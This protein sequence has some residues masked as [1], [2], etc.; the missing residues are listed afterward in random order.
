[1]LRLQP[2]SGAVLDVVAARGELQG[3]AGIAFAPD[4]TLWVSSYEDNRV[5][6]F[7]VSHAA[8]VPWQAGAR[9][10]AANSG[11]DEED[12]EGLERQRQI[13]ATLAR[14]REGPEG[15]MVPQRKPKEFERALDKAFNET[16]ATEVDLAAVAADSIARPS[17]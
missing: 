16:N 1:M 5:L 3:L 14:L 9:R 10:L 12:R 8:R 13:Q 2:G 4:G 6:S 15:G 7:N 17:E 11:E